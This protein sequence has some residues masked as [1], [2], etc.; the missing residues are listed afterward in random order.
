METLSAL[1]VWRQWIGDAGRDPLEELTF[2]AQLADYSHLLRQERGSTI[3]EWQP[4]A[5]P[6]EWS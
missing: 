4:G 6:I 1:A 2:H 3:G 5:P